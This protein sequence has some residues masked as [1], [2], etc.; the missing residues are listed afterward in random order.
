MS[1]ASIAEQPKKV[2]LSKANTEHSQAEFPVL[3]A[4]DG[5]DDTGWGIRPYT[6]KAQSAIFEVTNPIAGGVET[7]L[8]LVLDFQSKYPKHQ[9]GKFRLSATTSPNP[10]GAQNLPPNVRAALVVAAEK[11]TEAQKKEIAAYYHGIARRWLR[12]GRS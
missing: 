11:R 9:I 6:G 5:R 2:G 1:A 7:T 10:C 8:V 12:C 4:I 3:N